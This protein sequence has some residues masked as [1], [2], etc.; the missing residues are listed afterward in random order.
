MNCQ[1]GPLSSLYAET[2]AGLLSIEAGDGYIMEIERSDAEAEA[3]RRP[4]SAILRPDGS[5]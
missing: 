5:P 1:S 4:F 2:A 3:M